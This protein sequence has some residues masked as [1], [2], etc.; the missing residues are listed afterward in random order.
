[1]KT[2]SFYITF[3]VALVAVVLLWAGGAVAVQFL[4]GTVLNVQLE[5][6]PLD[7]AVSADGQLTFILTAAGKIHILDQNGNLFQSL[8]VE[9]GYDHIAFNTARRMIVLTG[10][11]AGTV[12]FIALDTVAD[13]DVTGSP[14]KGS[15]D[16]PVTVVVFSDFQ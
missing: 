1:M 13:I 14:F 9:P 11:K 5:D 12:K 15:E 16:A 7:V 4:P 2:T 8:A 6:N 10:S 3:I